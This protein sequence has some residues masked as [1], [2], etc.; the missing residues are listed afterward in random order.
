V[1]RKKA[2]EDAAPPGVA[3]VD[4]AG[5]APAADTAVEALPAAAAVQEAPPAP[6][7]AAG[8]ALPGGERRD[9]PGA[10]PWV[11]FGPY[12]TASKRTFLSCS[13]WRKGVVIE[14]GEVVFVYNVGLTR[15]YYGPDDVPKSSNTLRS[16]ELQLAMLLLEKADR[17]IRDQRNAG[18][19]H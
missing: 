4:P 8:S 6:E 10:R 11:K 14:G 9:P 18:G 2:N 13:I 5:A 19:G 1:I 7:G 15:T 12:P 3:A 16:S 17:H